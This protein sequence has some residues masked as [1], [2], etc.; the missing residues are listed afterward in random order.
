LGLGYSAADDELDVAMNELFQHSE[1][2]YAIFNS[3]LSTA[4]SIDTFLSCKEL[5]TQIHA[6]PWILGGFPYP[7]FFAVSQA[8]AFHGVMLLLTKLFTMGL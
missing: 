3:A 7:L 6:T 2:C 4:L 8:A 5:A 1:Q